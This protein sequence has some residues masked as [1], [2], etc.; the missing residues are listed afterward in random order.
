MHIA[1][2]TP[3]YGEAVVGGAEF[4]VR[5]FAERLVEHFGWSVDVLTTAATDLRTWDNELPVGAS[6]ER[7]VRVHRF[8]TARSRPPDFDERSHA[9]LARPNRVSESDALDWIR[10]QGPHSPELLAAIGATNADL[11]VFYP[12]LYEPT[13]VGVARARV[14]VVMHPASHDEAPAKLRVFD[15]VF[16]TPRAL[17][18]QTYSEANYVNRR[19][20]V[21][22]SRQI[23]LGL[24]SDPQPGA[25]DAARR[26]VGLGD[27]PYLL[28]LGRVDDG[29]GTGTLA[30]F[31][32]AYKEANPGPLALVLAGPVLHEPPRHPDIVVAGVVDED[33]KWGLLRGAL[34]LV[35]PSAFEAFSLVMIEAWHVERPVL[36]NARCGATREHCERSGGGL[37]FDGFG[38]FAAAVGR[39]VADARLRSEMGGA[40]RRYVEAEFTWP[41]ILARYR[42]F[43]ERTL[44]SS[45]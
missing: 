45:P 28:C 39:L 7:G 20:N 22:A 4:A 35:Q 14:P 13:V 23:V 21:G 19:F 29:K 43:L 1:Y 31:F 42:R 25:A 5:M 17:V 36:V 32:A 34:A 16:H 26:A 41:T 2:V 15:R 10:S 6:I 18:F 8:A 40:G 33:V 38:S 30:R 24:G 12:Y 27:R 44:A 9:V 3:R 37:W 11:V